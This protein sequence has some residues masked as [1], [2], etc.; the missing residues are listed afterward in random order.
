MQ[1][2]IQPISCPHGVNSSR[3]PVCLTAALQSAS[4]ESG[5]RTPP[6]R[7]SRV[8]V[9]G[10]G[11]AVIALAAVAAMFVRFPGAAE[12]PPEVAVAESDARELAL[13][14]Q[15]AKFR[16]V[17]LGNESSVTLERLLAQVAVKNKIQEDGFIHHVV[18][19]RPELAGLPFL[20]GDKCRI[21]AH[22]SKALATQS[23]ALNGTLPLSALFAP[24]NTPRPTN[25]ATE[26]ER[27]WSHIY[28]LDLAGSYGAAEQILAAQPAP[29]R[30]ILV[31]KLA[32][33]SDAAAVQAIARRALYDFNPK[34]RRDAVIAL[35][36]S[37]PE[38]YTATLID[39][40]RYPWS[41]VA[42]NAAE[43]LV[44][45]ERT[46]VVDQ[47]RQ[48][49]REPDPYFTTAPECDDPPVTSIREVVRVN[50]LK[51]C[52][53]C[54]TPVDGSAVSRN[55]VPFGRVPVPRTEIPV[56]YYA[57]SSGGEFVRADVTYLR[58]DFSARLPVADAHPWPAMQRFDFLVRTRPLTDASVR[59]AADLAASANGAALAF[60]ISSLSND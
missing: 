50:H 6:K 21:A 53:L 51:N 54:H 56:E 7:I 49:A 31:E 14:A 13:V 55:E 11:L 30:R 5:L 4:Q 52:V 58:Q 29:Y 35:R 33:S 24:A 28:S 47:L 37:R 60:A 38:D 1:P 17:G 45:L 34:I 12:P 43:T 3:C 9:A 23:V 32:T 48:L 19:D 40:F 59:P 36:A 41:N 20:M 18:A 46:D 26:A 39:G 42:Q 27:S 57:G 15:A 8:V 44:A 22:A 10:V 2:T 16:E 25:M